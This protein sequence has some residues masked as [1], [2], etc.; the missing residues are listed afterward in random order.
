MAAIG[1]RLG[2]DVVMIEKS[3]HPRF[4]IGESTTPLANLM[5]EDLAGLYDLPFLKDLSK[6]GIWQRSHPDVGCGLKRGFSFYHH[7]FDRPFQQLDDRSNQ[8]LVGASPHDRIAD[9]HWYRPDFDRFL[10]EQAQQAGVDFLDEV[11]LEPPD[12]SDDEVILSGTGPDGRVSARARFLIDAS[13]QRGYLYRTLNLPDVPLE[14]LPPTQGLYTQFEGVRR[15]EDMGIPSN[16]E[17]PPYPVDDAAMHHVFDGGW[18]WVLHFNNGITSAGVSATDE[19]AERFRFSDGAPAW[20]RL[21][22]HLPTVAEQFEAARFYL[23]FTLRDC[24]SN[25]AGS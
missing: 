7:E 11:Q 9:T 1:R 5:M 3:K 25:A 17:T 18:I 24:L 4:V 2:L 8:L 13:G 10:V 20:S 15:L 12:F 19:L 6:W 21:L 16:G 22:Q 14:R 23:S